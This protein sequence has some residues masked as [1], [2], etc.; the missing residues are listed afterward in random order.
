[1]ASEP[2][3]QSINLQVGDIIEFVAPT[4]SKINA[5]TFLIKYLDKEKLNI[6][7]QDGVEVIINI[8]EDGSLRNESIESIAILSR[9]DSPS[10]A[11]QNGLVANQWIDLHFGGELPVIMTGLITNL[12]E[13]QIEIK[14]V[15][16]ET[17]YI[18]F[19]YKGIPEDLPLE[20]IVKREPPTADK[21]ADLLSP[22]PEK[23]TPTSPEDEVDADTPQELEID[24]QDGTAVSPL[25]EPEFRE[26]VKNVL[27]AAD[28]IQFGEKLG[29]IAMMVEVPEEEKRYGIEKQ[30]TDLLNEMLSDIPNAE[31]TQTV[32]NNIHRMIERFKQLRMQF[33][34]F[35]ANGNA[36]MPDIQGADFKPLVHSLELLN[37]KL[38]WILPVVR[39]TKK[40]YDVD[41]DVASEYN[42]VDAE[43]LSAVR[44]AETEVIQAFKEGQIPDGQNG[45]DYLIKQIG[46]YWTPFGPPDS[47]T[48]NITTK[49]VET[50]ISAIVDNLYDFYSSVAKND[51]I[52]RKRFL[53]QE[54]NLGMN[55]LETQRIAGGGEVV[56]IKNVTRPDVM[57]IKSFITL[58]AA[59]VR[60]SHVNLPATNIMMKCNLSQ[61]YL[62]YW[63]MLNKLTSVTTKPVDKEPLEFDQD[64]YLEDIREYLPNESSDIDYKT[65]LENMI[66][67]TRV[68]FNLVKKHINGTLSMN[69]V[70]SYMEPFLVYQRDISFM[71]YQEITEFISEKITDWKKNYVTKKRDYEQLT[72]TASVKT[73]PLML[74]L[75]RQ[76][77]EANVEVNEGYR[78]DKVPLEKYSDG[79]LINLM[80]SIDCSRYFNDVVAMLSS[81]LMLPDGATKLLEQ[82]NLTIHKA[83]SQ[84]EKPNSKS[85]ATRVLSKKYL[86]IDELTDDNGKQIKYD[87]QY[88]KTYYD[89]IEDHIAELDAIPE[90]GSKI[91]HLQRK[92]TEST[93][94]SSD[95]AKREAEA[96]ILGYRPVKEGDYAIVVISDE[97][98]FYYKRRDNTWV[99]DESI[100]TS[101]MA[102]SNDLFCNLDEK[103]IS[104]ND[105]CVALPAAAI[106]IQKTAI[107]EMVNEFSEQLKEGSK[108][109][110]KRIMEKASN[111]SSRLTPLISLLTSEFLKNDTIK[112]ELGASAKEVVLEKS[113]YADVLSLILSQS[114][115][116]KRQ[117]DITRFVAY[118]TRPANP[119]EDQWWL[120]CIASN[121][122][123]LPTFISKLADVYVN[124]G[125]YFL[126]LQR[127][128]AQQGE[129]GGDGE[130]IV[131]KY[132]GWIITRIDFSTD[133]GFTE[134]GFVMRSREVMEA[135]LGRAIAQAP[136]EKVEEF[137]DPEAEKIARVMR[138][139]SRY[140]GLNTNTLEEFVVS[141]TAKL[142][143]KSMPARADYEA[144]IRAA[145]AKG[146]KKKLD[147]YD[148][149][150]DQTLILLTMSFLLIA[151]QTSIPG[152]RTRKTYPGCV[153]SFSGYPV[154]GNGDD[155]G[156]DYMACVADGIKSSIE[157]WNSIK[158]LSQKKI[159]SKMKAFIDK[160]I[161]PTDVI[162]ERIVAKNEYDAVNQEEYIPAE[163]DITN[164]INFLPPL[165]PVN[166]TVLPP[167]KE[168]QDQFLTDIKRG[169]KGQFEKINALRSKIIYLALS[170]E[171]AVQKVVTK[172]IAD[173]QAI[174]SNAAKVPFLENACCNE[175]NDETF[176]YFADREGSIVMDNNI[177]KDLRA[178]LDDVGAMSTASILFDP[179]DTRIEFPSLPPEF[180]EETIYRAFIVYCKYNSDIPVSEELRAI[181]MDKPDDFNISDS[182]KDKIKKLKRDGRNFD[183]ETLARLMSVINKKNMVN[184]NLRTLVLSNIQRLRDRL[185]AVN[186]TEAGVLPPQ[187]I[188]G[189]LNVIDRF[190]VGDLP[191]DRDTDEVR[192]MKN[193]LQTINDQM[194]TV[195]SDFVRRNTNDKIH[196]KFIECLMSITEFR[197]DPT[198]SDSTVFQ[199]ADYAKSVSWLIARVF[200]N[201]IINEV[202]YSNVKVPACWNLSEQHQQDIRAQAR[203]H[204][205]PLSKF[206]GDAQI[207]SLLQVFQFEG[208]QLWAISDDTMYIAP[209]NTPEG[210]VQSVFDDKMV[211]YLF[212]FYI[213]NALINMMELVEREEFYDEKLERPSNPLLREVDVVLGQEGRAPM[214]EI[215]SGEKKQMS[216]KVAGVMAAFMAVVCQDKNTINLNY[217][218]LMEKVT[219]SKEKE[220]DQI[221][222]FLT[223]LTDEEREIENMFKNHR[224]GRWSV[225][226]Q[227]GFR[228]YEGDTYDNERKQ[229]EERTIREARLNKIDGVTRGLMDVFELDAIVEENEAQMIEDQELEIEYN[230][231]DNNIGDADYG[232]EM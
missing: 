226:M 69:A 70:L 39:N 143:A 187:F 92:I 160:F 170:I 24:E 46:K 57:S 232:D 91:A 188:S 136:N 79:E 124:D 215:M 17:I 161:M 65:Y 141:Q 195:I 140:M 130:A 199:M 125:N 110:D 219:R 164:W 213:L 59:A 126:E 178:V 67:K 33:S 196:T 231:E 155:S 42:D 14:L 223:E 94:M 102:D 153:K 6:I 68:L 61:N 49:H 216:E 113:P 29:A 142:L 64:K 72:R 194:Q 74:Q 185:S 224:I 203:D 28:Q 177:V 93:G 162:Q 88:D 104:V 175:S 182:I 55:T 53:I 99:R 207:K 84:A 139:I 121:V 116:V 205:A 114:D 5:K 132:S 44:S 228:V 174:L 137:G 218:D 83:E 62:S 150:Y 78:L 230:G 197:P 8:N 81:D 151:I 152:L 60:F 190:G 181:C 95:D 168:F 26:R 173:H 135:D 206:Y 87:K 227:K 220:K 23:S 112:F 45:Y 145:E 123:L 198:N 50:N 48:G 82:E 119:D 63:R 204:Y 221:V 108:A 97:E 25:P 40:L 165:K 225:G 117:N 208:R 56:K 4:D 115:F 211:K 120:Y 18:D 154:F 54:Y 30:T 90:Q 183:N 180:D 22:I 109:I 210:M 36:Q 107:K 37:Q 122:K 73:L 149:A 80:N 202:A 2:I 9:A 201:I 128:A 100:P 193:Y 43:T 133:E 144:A 217:D 89:V 200:P 191:A 138:A 32:L 163:H 105:D 179:T 157:P 1:M 176:K 134:E 66:P 147:P 171:T 101:T 20:Q 148:I 15:D 76:S 10:Y 169:T 158:K 186:D 103:C 77:P 35:D 127:I 229:I 38:Y 106:E 214:L 86:S 212:K 184:L 111:A 11:R 71:Q 58:P 85:C 96:M 146:K 21:P 12:D 16:D 222:E 41:E 166:A 31:R 3:E 34:K 19:A 189:M 7:G 47:D 118:Y 192:S 172:N 159:V 98:V 27:I 13:D 156:I 75:L 131:D 51:N 129:E 167:T 52:K 209:V